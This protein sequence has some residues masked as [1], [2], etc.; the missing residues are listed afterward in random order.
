MTLRKNLRTIVIIVLPILLAMGKFVDWI[1][2]NFIKSETPIA[3]HLSPVS[4][5]I[6]QNNVIK[7]L[8][9]NQGDQNNTNI[10]MHND[11]DHDKLK[12]QKKVTAHPKIYL[13]YVSQDKQFNIVNY[14]EEDIYYVG[15]KF[16]KMPKS[17]NKKRAMV[18]GRAGND[19]FDYYF[20]SIFFEPYIRQKIK[21][22]NQKIFPLDIYIAD[23]SGRLFVVRYNIITE[24]DVNSLNI[25]P[26]M[27]SIN[28]IE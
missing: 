5:N 6:I 18:Q 26:Q 27:L 1:Y 11:Q 22:K 14:G 12:A 24:L 13:E 23:K 20:G 2:K 3:S 28:E 16:D 7:N 17:L 25:Y 15:L 4:N 19:K 10:T 21:E 8:T 9:L